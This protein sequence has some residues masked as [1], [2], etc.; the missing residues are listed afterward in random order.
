[1]RCQVAIK[2]QNI[3]AL[4]GCIK[5]VV[6]LFHLHAQQVVVGHQHTRSLLPQYVLPGQTLLLKNCCP[7]QPPPAS[8]IPTAETL[9]HIFSLRTCNLGW[10]GNKTLCNSIEQRGSGALRRWPPEP[11]PRV[12][13][14]SGSGRRLPAAWRSATWPRMI[15][16]GC[17]DCVRWGNTSELRREGHL[18]ET[19]HHKKSWET[20]WLWCALISDCGVDV[21]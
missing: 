2:V 18:P 1:M 12:P 5:N 20:P 7:R 4:R 6:V 13:W 14:S 11:P 17:Y 3:L 15:V 16:L 8:V 19:R 10:Q 9:K 21:G